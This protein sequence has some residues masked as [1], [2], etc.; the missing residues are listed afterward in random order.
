MSHR[1][2][3]SAVLAVLGFFLLPSVGLGIPPKPK[4]E[5]CNDGRDN[6]HNGLTDCADP[7]CV[8]DPACTGEGSPPAQMTATWVFTGGSGTDGIEGGDALCTLTSDNASNGTYACNLE[9]G[10][11]WNFHLSDKV[12]SPPRG[13]IQDLCATFS[14]QKDN[15]AVSTDPYVLSWDSSCETDTC[16]VSIAVDFPDGAF[17]LQ[18][19]T[20][21]AVS[22]FATASVAPTGTMS[23]FATETPPLIVH[24]SHVDVDLREY[25]KG[26]T[27]A[28]CRYE[29]GNGAELQTS[30]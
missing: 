18:G 22:V 13:G 3:L 21:G 10:A 12:A 16:Q 29:D 14:K 20:L 19:A 11:S 6:D 26:R 8:D 25:G 9:G 4:V 30:Y 5:V 23:P 2:A 24:P 7:V 1:V 27:I 15:T 28:R 17:E